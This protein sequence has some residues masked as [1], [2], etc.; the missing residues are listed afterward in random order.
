MYT[1]TAHTTWFGIDVT[2]TA[3]AHTNDA[4]ENGIYYYLRTA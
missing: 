4:N 1:S 2:E 3:D